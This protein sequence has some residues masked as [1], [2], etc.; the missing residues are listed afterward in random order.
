MANW[1]GS[2][3][4]QLKTFESYLSPIDD[5][6]VKNELRKSFAARVF[7]DHPSMKGE[8]SVAPTAGLGEKAVDLAT[9]VI[10]K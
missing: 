7:G 6:A 5:D 8:P 9:K 1:A 4:V 3:A 2:L 10:S